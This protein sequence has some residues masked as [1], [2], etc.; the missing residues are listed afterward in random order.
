MPIL[1]DEDPNPLLIP[2]LCALMVIGLYATDVIGGD[3]EPQ[4]APAPVVATTP[5]PTPAPTA[6]PRPTEQ[7]RASR[8]APRPAPSKPPLPVSGW[9]ARYWV[10]A[11]AWALTPKAKAVQACES[12]G[13]VYANVDPKAVNPTGKYRG[14]WQMDRDFWASY[15]GTE[16]AARPDLASRAAQNYV[17]YRG[18][19]SHQRRLGNG[20]LPWECA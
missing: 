2:F 4:P 14:A 17:A 11:Q 16:L 6:E 3:P 19:V 8:S 20:W 13:G 1:R 5:A 18:Y 9:K 7:E 10:E 15:G 12:G